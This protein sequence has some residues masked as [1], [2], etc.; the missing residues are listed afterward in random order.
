MIRRRRRT[1]CVACNE[2]FDPDPRNRTKVKAR[3]RV[4]TKCGPVVGHRVAVQ[5]YAASESQDRPRKKA[6]PATRLEGASSASPDS[7]EPRERT[8]SPSRVEV[9]VLASRIQMNTRGVAELL[10]SVG[11]LMAAALNPAPN[12][13]F[14]QN[15]PDRFN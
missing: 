7:P 3:Q 10:L 11:G 5:R 13:H 2:L 15:K 4:C 6:A 1:R 14:A 9:E 8:A 12:R